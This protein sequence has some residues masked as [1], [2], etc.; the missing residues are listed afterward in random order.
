MKHLKKIQENQQ[1]LEKK[2]EP[3]QATK[4]FS[5]FYLEATK[6]FDLTRSQVIWYFD[7]S[8]LAS[9]KQNKS[10]SR[11]PHSHPKFY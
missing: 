1:E 2:C 11:I 6:L 9:Q 3:M 5:R 7:G 4:R 8:E 10:L